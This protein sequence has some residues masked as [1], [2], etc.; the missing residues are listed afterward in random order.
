[1]P[2][3]LISDVKGCFGQFERIL[4][5]QHAGGGAIVIALIAR[6]A[7]AAALSKVA[8]DKAGIIAEQD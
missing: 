8:V 1:M 5:R 2:L 4:R 7:D 3:Q 6:D